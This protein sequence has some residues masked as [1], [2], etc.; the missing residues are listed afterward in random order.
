VIVP[1]LVFAAFS[2]VIPMTRA[3]DPTVVSVV[4]EQ[5]AVND[6]ALDA[7]QT[8]VE[9]VFQVPDPPNQY[10]SAIR[11]PQK[12]KFLAINCQVVEVEL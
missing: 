10:L 8:A 5:E 7:L 3:G 1:R 9:I 12:P 2:T 11:Y 6:K 4:P